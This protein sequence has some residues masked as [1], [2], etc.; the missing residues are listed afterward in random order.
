MDIQKFLKQVTKFNTPADSN[1]IQ[2]TKP[3]DKGI[4]ETQGLS[5]WSGAKNT[6]APTTYDSIEDLLGGYANSQGKLDADGVA[7]LESDFRASGVKKITVGGETYNI[8]D[9]NQASGSVV[10]GSS[11]NDIFFAKEGTATYVSN[12]GNDILL[13]PSK[14][15]DTVTVMGDSKADA[16]SSAKTAPSSEDDADDFLTHIES[17]DAG[18][19]ALNSFTQDWAAENGKDVSNLSDEDKLNAQKAFET[20]L[21]QMHK[22]TK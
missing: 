13:T 1:E 6:K 8:I 9:G 17:T 20:M 18:K 5:I 15:G 19:K 12:G 21:L 3:Y 7:H 4:M 22:K 14:V 16:A 2:Q 11:A 10:K